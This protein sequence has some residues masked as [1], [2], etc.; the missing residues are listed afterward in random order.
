MNDGEKNF[1]KEEWKEF[2]ENFGSRFFQLESA[3]LKAYGDD[4]KK[5][6]YEVF[7]S[8]KTL[9]Q[10]IGVVAGF[11]FTG[12][13]Y[14]KNL[15]LFLTGEFFLFSTIFYGLYWEQ[16]AYKTN[17]ES[18]ATEI[19]RVKKLFADRYSIFKKIYDKALSDIT[20]GNEISIP[21]SDIGDLQKQGNDLMEK[22]AIQNESK[23]IGD[24]FGWLMTFFAI[25]GAC[26]LLSFVHFCFW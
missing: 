3:T 7:G 21:K 18:S 9:V 4:Q 25:G 14:V 20:N 12:L 1:S 19:I 26:L 8:S 24:P 15:P 11:G 23:S 5:L 17:L 6:I 16:K 13:G 2:Y 22:F 10:T